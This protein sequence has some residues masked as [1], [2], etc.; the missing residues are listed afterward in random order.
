M[1]ALEGGGGLDRAEGPIIVPLNPWPPATIVP[2]IDAAASRRGMH[3]GSGRRTSLRRPGGDAALAA[4]GAANEIDAIGPGVPMDRRGPG[5]HFAHCQLDP[6]GVEQRLLLPQ[7]RRAEDQKQRRL[8]QVDA[9]P[10][11]LFDAGF[12]RPVDVRVRRYLAFQPELQGLVQ[13][14]RN[15]EHQNRRG[16]AETGRDSRPDARPIGREIDEPQHGEGDDEHQQH[17]GED[18]DAGREREPRQPPRAFQH[19]PR[20]GQ[21]QP[22]RGGDNVEDLAEEVHDRRQLYL[23]CTPQAMLV[24]SRN[25]RGLCGDVLFRRRTNLNRAS[26]LH[27]EQHGLLQ[28]V[29]ANLG[30]CRL[31]HPVV[32]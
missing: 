2:R 1:A 15:D 14:Q 17:G 29:V 26:I 21:Q 4:H 23:F 13:Y 25:C 3:R 27:P 12:P 30:N 18:G 24:G 20:R 8:L 9:L 19:L 11:D 22:H 5:R 16:D 28:E 10:V 6:P 7:S 32:R 31:V